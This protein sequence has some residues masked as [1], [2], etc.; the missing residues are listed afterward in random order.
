MSIL[1]G[2]EATTSRATTVSGFPLFLGMRSESLF[3]A[4]LSQIIIDIIIND[5]VLELKLDQSTRKV[6]EDP[7]AGVSSLDSPPL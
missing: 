4:F 6:P 5:V 1:R 2:R 3:G 7:P